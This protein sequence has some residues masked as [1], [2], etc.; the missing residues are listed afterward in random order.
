MPDGLMSREER[1]KEIEK[2]RAGQSRTK[3]KGDGVDMV[4]RQMEEQA[5]KN[6]YPQFDDFPET[7]LTIIRLYVEH[8]KIPETVVPYKYNRKRY[9]LWVKE[10][11]EIAELCG[12][13]ADRAM[14][15]AGEDLRKR[16]N[17]HL[18]IT[19]PKGEWNT[20]YTLL[21][22]ALIKI[23]AEKQ[24]EAKYTPKKKNQEFIKKINF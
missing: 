1:Q 15:I 8:F 14:E 18:I 6:D 17:W 4:I 5:K 12:H 7:L 22:T 11:G 2:V 21:S 13:H 10:L 23:N 19:R 24:E 16:E 20:I 9:N 3:R